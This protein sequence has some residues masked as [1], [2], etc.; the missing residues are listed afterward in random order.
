MESKPSS[1]AS[2]DRNTSSRY[3]WRVRG[4]KLTLERTLTTVE[5]AYFSPHEFPPDAPTDAL[6]ALLVDQL[7]HGRLR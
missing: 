7:N 5:K 3:A 6:L 1:D 4:G 2:T